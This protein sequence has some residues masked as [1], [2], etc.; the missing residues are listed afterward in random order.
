MKL[1]ILL[2]ISLFHSVAAFPTGAGGCGGGGAAVGGTH[3][4]GSKTLTSGSLAEAGFSLLL[5]GSALENNFVLDLDSDSILTLVA[6]GGTPFKGVLM[7]VEATD[8]DVQDTAALTPDDNVQAAGVCEAPV[9]GVTHSNSDDKTTASATLRFETAT[10]ITLDVTVVVQN[11]DSASVFYY[12]SFSGTAGDAAAGTDD[13]AAPTDDAT[14]TDDAA[15]TAD[16]TTQAPTAEP[17]AS[18]PTMPPSLAAT[19]T[20]PSQVPTLVPT[21]VS[22]FPS[23]VPSSAPSVPPGTPTMPPSVAAETPAPTA[24]PTQDTATFEPFP[25]VAP[26]SGAVAAA[27]TAC[28]VVVG[29]MAVTLTTVLLG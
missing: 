19:T 14:A 11:D 29:I 1:S 21:L 13:A 17:T 20:E 24:D 4:D 23:D 27:S 12:E 16:S 3:L 10:E 28:S 18:T 8:V 25:T 26:G 9:G 6:T 2:L 5:D 15:P 22:N 7:R